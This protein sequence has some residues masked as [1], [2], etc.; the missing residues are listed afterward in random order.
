V[1]EHGWRWNEIMRG[2]EQV[3]VTQPGRLHVYENFAPNGRGDV[4]I[5]EIE[6]TTDSVDHKRLHVPLPYSCFEPA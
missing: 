6:P 5:L 2:K 4:H 1:T 3:S